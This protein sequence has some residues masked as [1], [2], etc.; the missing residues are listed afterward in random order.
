MGNTLFDI[1]QKYL[2]LISLLEETGGELT[3]ELEVELMINEENFK[4]KFSNYRNLVVA[5]EAHNTFLS[6]EISRLRDKIKVNDNVVKRLKTFQIGSLKLFGEVNK[7]G[8]KS[9]AFDNFKASCYP[10]A[11]VIEDEIAIS[12][13]IEQAIND[14]Y[15]NG[16]TNVDLQG[17]NIVVDI[18]IPYDKTDKVKELIDFCTANLFTIFFNIKP[19]KA[20]IKTLL[21]EGKE[22]QGF[23]LG[24]TDV[25]RI[26]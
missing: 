21:Q 26:T 17:H 14:F 1:E 11:V 2:E 25:L 13:N 8:N 6:D 5:K 9:F 16:S 3:P 22:V 23:K 24:S 10:L 19:V 20:E 7:S 18:R 15:N 4:D 12:K